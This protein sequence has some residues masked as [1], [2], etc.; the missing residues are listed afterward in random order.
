MKAY[1][2][3]L[4]RALAAEPGSM[5]YAFQA[6]GRLY[7]TAEFYA[8]ALELLDE[9]DGLCPEGSPEKLRVWREKVPVYNGLAHAV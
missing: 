1:L 5:S 7:P 4:D 9:A 8:T 2:E 6:A 3:H